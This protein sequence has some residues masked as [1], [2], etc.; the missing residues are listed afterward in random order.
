MRYIRHFSITLIRFGNSNS[1]VF[2]ANHQI[3]KY[4]CCHICNIIIFQVNYR[5]WVRSTEKCVTRNIY[6]KNPYAAICL[7]KV[8]CAK[9]L[10][11]LLYIRT[12]YI[13][14]VISFSWWSFERRSF[15][16]TTGHSV[17]LLW[18]LLYVGIKHIIYVRFERFLLLIGCVQ[19]NYII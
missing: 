9:L 15:S 5:N 18:I 4:Y 13:I 19:Q 8:S 6:Q 12:H 7:Y 11:S 17:L 10:K 14:Q 1:K 16:S 2:A 3:L